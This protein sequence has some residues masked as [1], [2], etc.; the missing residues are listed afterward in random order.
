MKTMKILSTMMLTA[1]LTLGFA[2]CSDD[3]DLKVKEFE[4]NISGSWLVVVPYGVMGAGNTIYTF[5]PDAGASP[6][7]DGYDGAVVEYVYYFKSDGSG[8]GESVYTGRYTVK[9][10]DVAIHFSNVND[11]G[12]E[13]TSDETWTIRRMTKDRMQCDDTQMPEDHWWRIINLVR[14]PSSTWGDW[15]NDFD[16]DWAHEW[17]LPDED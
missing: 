12:Y 14:V 5:R 13:W 3:D 17:D 15:S 1:A 6:N 2:A 16:W 11:E 4:S 8:H 9:G 10:S 7:S